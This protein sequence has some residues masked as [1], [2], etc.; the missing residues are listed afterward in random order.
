MKNVSRR[1]FVAGSAVVAGL[2]GLAA[3]SSDT[4]TDG[5]VVADDASY[6]IDPDGDDVEAKWTSEE[7]RDGW[8]KVTNPDDG[9]EL[10]VMDASKIIQVD[11]L[12]FKDM[13]GNGKLD[14]YEDW[15]Q[16]VADRAA[17]L[18]EVLTA[19][20]AIQL[21]WHGG[22]TD[23]SE[24]AEDPDFGAVTKGSRAGVSR[25]QS[26]IDSYA[27]D[28][29]WINTVQSMCEESTYGIPYLNSTDQYQLYG[30]PDNVAISASMDKDVWRRAGMFLGRAWRA[31]GVRCLL[32]PQVDV[33]SNPIGCRLSGSVSED[34]A[35]NRDFTA[36]FS[37]G[38]QST[39]AD[40][41]A[42]DDQGWGK[43]SVA[44]ML[45]HYLGEGCSEGGRNDHSSTGAFN[46]FPGD[47]FEAHL[48]PFLDGGLNLDSST[49]QMASVM[50]CYGINYDE[51]E[52]Y[53][54][55]V[56]SGYNA[57][58][59]AVLRNAGWD[60]M[61][62]TDWGILN[63]Q[64]FGVEDLTEA[65]RY[66]KMVEAGIDQYG[67]GFYPEVGAEAYE[68]M[69]TNLGEDAALARVQN[70]ARRIITVMM[71]VDLFEQPYS[72][73]TAAREV[74][75]SEDA[76]A[77]GVESSEKSIVMLKNAGNV[78]SAD[79]ISG[80]PKC[81]VPQTLI[82]PGFMS[83][84]PIHFA[85]GIS[86]DLL[87]DTFEIVTDTVAEEGTGTS[88][89][90]FTGE[91]TEGVFQESDCT[92]L[93]AEDLADCEYAIVRIKNPQ[94]A[95]DGVSG[96]SGFGMTDGEVEYLPVTL[97][98]EPYTATAARETSIGGFVVDGE[99]ENR[100]YKDKTSAAT[101]YSDLE[102][103]KSTREAM[104]DGKVIVIVDADR[105]M[106]FSELE[107]YADV[108]LMSYAFMGNPADQGFVNII[109]GKT[110]PSAL[111]PFQQPANMETVETSCEDV[112]R[113][114]ECYVDTEGNTYDFCF[115]L[116][117]S[118]VIDD[119]RT[120]TYGVNPLTEPETAIEYGE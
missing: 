66:D 50:P 24:D 85:P 119:E 10:G 116:N 58:N 44:A 16:P 71:N 51:D 59:L 91:V 40:D 5:A 88:V 113:D 76:L 117:W 109:T 23:S 81:Y 111:L 110:E 86:E 87:S 42:T 34:P 77:F 22:T 78:I 3:C 112:P 9:A 67:G 21:M 65:E 41:E 46:V 36:A 14:L 103:V 49:G 15:R 64:T 8:T 104:P 89:S 19:E 100:S 115:G 114:L 31:T 90:V 53:G 62:C 25:L 57:R 20:E 63:S 45:K 94:D 43:D 4:T 96:G 118:G 97:Q 28:I 55:N 72:D 48:I 106:V 93:T 73:R 7:T 68:I 92:R 18:A 102:L 60:G 29:E 56:G 69:K 101:N 98:Y 17:A 11:G 83:T 2:A 99:K 82:D 35:V 74:L 38:L 30:I 27:S 33:Y 84:D 70:S 37:A 75:E 26:D 120:A 79:G 6:P 61:Y 12:A 80:K 108:I 32:G 13:N 54:E 95:N 52:K 47:N 1:G 107:P 105:P 39:W